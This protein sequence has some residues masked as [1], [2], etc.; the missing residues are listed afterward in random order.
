MNLP[1][2]RILTA[3]GRTSQAGKGLRVTI[4]PQELEK[5][6]IENP[7]VEEVRA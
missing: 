3:L 1:V 6:S 4:Q 2:F 5:S 7:R